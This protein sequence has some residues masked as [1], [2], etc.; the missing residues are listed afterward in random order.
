MV[1]CSQMVLQGLFAAHC[2]VAGRKGAGVLV[3]NKKAGW[4]TAGVERA[5]VMVIISVMAVCNGLW[6]FGSDLGRGSRDH[7]LRFCC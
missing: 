6:W 2:Y 1:F 5:V 4:N 3:I 7:G